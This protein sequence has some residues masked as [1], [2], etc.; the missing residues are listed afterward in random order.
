MDESPRL[1]LFQ[2][3]GIEIEYM[4]V[5]R[6]T[7]DVA[8]LTDRVLEA[9]AG[10]IVSETDQGP[11]SWSNELVLHVV[12]LKTNGPA[13]AL[14]PLPAHFAADVRRIDGILAPLGARLL[15]GGM[16]P[17]MQPD[18]ETRLWP[19]EYGAV[20]ETFHRIFDCRGHGWS[21]LQSMHVNL[22]FADD[23][24]FGRLHAAIRAVLPLLPALAASSPFVEGEATGW[25][26]S[27]LRAYR[28]NARR[29]PSVSGVVVPEPHYTRA[30]YEGVL[31]AGIYQDLAPFDPEGV[32]RYEWVNARGAIA[33]FDRYAIEIRVLDTQE[34]PTADLAVAAATSEILK[35]LVRRD[36]DELRALSSE[37]LAKTLWSA[38][39]H[40]EWGVIDDRAHQRALG[41]P[42]HGALSLGEAWRALLER[43]APRHRPFRERLDLILDRG[44]L[45]RRLLEAAGPGPT[46]ARL[47]GVYGR[48]ADALAADQPFL[49]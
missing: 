23:D 45:A 42:D 43:A 49:P 40:G 16:H 47:A 2:G 36:D 37:A 4:I 34:G 8:P 46:R 3:Y 29:V 39:E 9:A 28:S 1:G 27:R 35:D 21:N 26:D 10:E 15:P 19:H 33:R 30:A 25:L 7:L 41:L 44:P 11:L 17:W 12:E 22:P 5:D 31:L 13:P 24:E 18:T 14:A 20:Y 32:L 6:R 38:A 48:L